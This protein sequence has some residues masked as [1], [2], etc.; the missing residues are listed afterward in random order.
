MTVYTNTCQPDSGLPRG[1]RS[2]DPLRLKLKDYVHPESK[3]PADFGW[4]ASRLHLGIRIVNMADDEGNVAIETT[5]YE[6]VPVVDHCDVESWW[7]SPHGWTSTERSHPWGDELDGALTDTRWEE[8]QARAYLLDVRH[9]AGC[10]AGDPEHA[11]TRARW[12]VE[13]S[14]LP[15]TDDLDYQSFPHE[16]LHSGR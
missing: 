5:L 14:D 8:V 6:E 13:F 2:T 11:V 7:P 1:D 4:A 15:L 16:E 12:F 9:E 3:D 10:A